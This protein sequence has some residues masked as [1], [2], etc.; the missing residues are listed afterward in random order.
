MSNHFLACIIQILHILLILYIVITPFYVTNVLYLK[1]HLVIL[2]S[3]IFHWM[4]NN[5]V[6]VLTLAETY[7]T[8]SKKEESFFGRLV[9][10]VYNFTNSDIRMLTY[11][12]LLYSIC[13][14]YYIE[15]PVSLLSCLQLPKK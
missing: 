5:D 10:P 15:R 1:L 11:L 13:H 6:C 14:W 2:V 9:S 12:L 3:I 4:V 7:L 8:G